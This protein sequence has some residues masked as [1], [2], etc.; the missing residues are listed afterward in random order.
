MSFKDWTSQNGERWLAECSCG[1][2]RVVLLNNLKRKASTS[3]GCFN[4]EKQRVLH[5]THGQ[6]GKQTSLYLRW[7]SMR[8]RCENKKCK[9]YHNYGG[10][11]ITVCERWR[12]S[13][14]AFRDDIGEPPSS[15]HTIDRI[16]NN[17]NYEPSNVRWATR[18]EQM[19]NV[20][21]NR[22]VTYNGETRCLTEWCDILKITRSSA[23]RRLDSGMSPEEALS[24][25]KKKSRKPAI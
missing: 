20:R 4:R 22:L 6:A 24:I 15:R 13:F 14:E 25:P 1:N 3:C 16:D 5:T 11:G 17:G 2:R 9:Q 12:K 8:N 23:K 7:A 18:K 10:R 21:Y 19:H